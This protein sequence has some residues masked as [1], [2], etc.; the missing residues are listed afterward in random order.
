MN[1]IKAE[2]CSEIRGDSV[3]E[4]SVDSLNLNLHGKDSNMLKIECANINNRNFLI[5]QARS[6]KPHGIYVVEFLLYD[7][8]H[9]YRSLH[10]L[11]K[12]NHRRKIRSIEIRGTYIFCKTEVDDNFVHVSSLAEVGVIRK[13]LGGVTAVTH[14]DDDGLSGGN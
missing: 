5:K 13:K 3:S 8:V 6:K 12:E 11:R 9:I 2:L 10:N 7:K 1:Q 14:T 4:I